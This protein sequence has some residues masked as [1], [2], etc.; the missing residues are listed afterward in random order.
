VKT[1]QYYGGW[2]ERL[3]ADD[4]TLDPAVWDYRIP[5]HPDK[6]LKGQLAES[7]EFPEPGTHV[8]HLRIGIRWQNLPP[9]NGR[10]SPLMTWYFIISG[11][12][13]WAEV[14]LTESVPCRHRFRQP[15]IGNRC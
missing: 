1:D 14:L 12:M 8:V 2:L 7:W 6:Y 13:H 15:D 10:N 4:W 3:V 5:W 9:A 11:Y